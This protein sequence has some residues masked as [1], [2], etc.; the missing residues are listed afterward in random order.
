[1]YH[2]DDLINDT[3]I[4]LINNQEY[5]QWQQQ[6]A[7]A[8]H[9][10]GKVATNVRLDCYQT[11]DAMYINGFQIMYSKP[12]AKTL[13]SAITEYHGFDTPVTISRP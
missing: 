7:I 11:D 13:S 10:N 2:T 6:K 3:V 12:D 8:F 9:S 4:E 5:D 1:M